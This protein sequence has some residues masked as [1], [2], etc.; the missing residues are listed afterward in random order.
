MK[1]KNKIN[2]KNTQVPSVLVEVLRLTHRAHH[3]DPGGFRQPHGY[4]GARG[5]YEAV[6][7]AGQP[8]DGLF[9]GEEQGSDD[10]ACAAHYR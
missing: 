9:E 4:H 6:H 1:S 10:G 3:V 5:C 8:G 2:F 7:G